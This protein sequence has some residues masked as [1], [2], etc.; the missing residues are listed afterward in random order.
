LEDLKSVHDCRKDP[1][2]KEYF[3]ETIFPLAFRAVDF[4]VFWCHN[5]TQS[6]RM[7]YAQGAGVPVVGRKW[8]GVGETLGLSGLPAAETLDELAE[9]I[10]EIVREPRLREELEKL[11]WR[12][13]DR[14]SFYDQA[15]KHLLLEETLRAGMNLPVLDGEPVEKMR[16]AIG[17]IRE[18]IASERVLAACHYGVGRSA[19]VVTGYLCSL[20]FG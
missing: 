20:G 9:K 17:W 8:E 15:K 18:H 7:A 10:A 14:Y 12:C 16:E 6:G 3:Q 13:A 1:C 2:L 5:A 4:A 11:S 19:S